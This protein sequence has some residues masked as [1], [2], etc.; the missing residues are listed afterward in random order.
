MYVSGCTP[1]TYFTKNRKHIYVGRKK[2]EPAEDIAVR[3][4]SSDNYLDLTD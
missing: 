4:K 3:K 2:T 1:G